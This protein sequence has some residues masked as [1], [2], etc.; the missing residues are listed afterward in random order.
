MACILHSHGH[1]VQLAD[2]GIST[3]EAKVAKVAVC[4]RWHVI[5]GLM[6]MRLSLSVVWVPSLPK[7]AS[8]VVA[9][10]VGILDNWQDY[11]KAVRAPTW[12]SSCLRIRRRKRSRN[13]SPVFARR[14]TCVVVLTRIE[15][16]E[17]G[18]GAC[19]L[20]ILPRHF[21]EELCFSPEMLFGDVEYAPRRT[22]AI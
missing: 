11:R 3:Q 13:D 7:F 20:R 19:F 17:V 4:E 5:F 2:V 12:R 22:T 9:A 15:R 18:G 6:R 21:P 14:S 16:G 8:R 1:R 10:P